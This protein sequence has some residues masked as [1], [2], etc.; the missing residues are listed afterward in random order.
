MLLME[1]NISEN[2]HT[3]RAITQR[4]RYKIKSTLKIRG[5]LRP[6]YR[7][8]IN[9]FIARERPSLTLISSD[10][11][12]DTKYMLEKL[13]FTRHTWTK[14]LKNHTILTVDELVDIAKYLKCNLDDLV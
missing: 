2:A 1:G 4:T 13:G 5:V 14:I 6:K 8:K 12:E 9:L 11:N 7:N 10:L 3:R